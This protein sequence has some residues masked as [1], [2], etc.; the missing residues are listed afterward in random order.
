MYH[1]I[2]K[3]YR[4]YITIDEYLDKYNHIS[5]PNIKNGIIVDFNFGLDNRSHRILPII[6]LATI[7]E[8]KMICKIFQNAYNNTYPFKKLEDKNEI[9]YMIKNQKY[10]WFIFRTIDNEIVGCVG[11][12]L[13]F[14]KKRGYIF[15]FAIKKRFH[16]K[17][18]L[19]KVWFITIYFLWNHYKNQ[20]LVWTSEVRTFCTIPQYAE[21][22]VGLMPVG[23]LPN[24]DMFNNKLE[25]EF[26]FIVYDKDVFKKYRSRK[27][28]R[29]LKE[30]LPYYKYCN[31][32]YD[33]GRPI[34]KNP[35]LNLNKRKI[36]RLKDKIIIKT[37][38]D[39]Y[40]NKIK[41]LRIK[42]SKSYFQYQYNLISNNI[43][44]IKY[45]IESLEELVVF[46]REL[47]IYT[48]KLNVN[49]IE[50][51]VSAYNP[52]IQ[53]IFNEAGFKPRGYIPCLDYNKK[54][55]SFQDYILFNHY[56]GSIDPI[57]ESNLII[58]AKRLYRIYQEQNFLNNSESKVSQIFL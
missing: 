16:G 41:S 9:K 46:I 31:D 5:L 24:K 44:N 54:T 11:A 49:Y 27:K 10:K 22:L 37:L 48:E 55:N 38:S 34:I 33:L 39:K 17:I 50:C 3:N 13:E 53:K 8:A 15:G 45:F 57:I 23:F 18:D 47:R 21:S 56:K 14:G 1:L 58:E 4:K 43:D 30:I 35:I 25:S 29:I 12:K 19:L 28:I 20:I 42:N 2:Q 6:Q 52:K 36:L 40:N 51:Y 32:R 7:K 26:F